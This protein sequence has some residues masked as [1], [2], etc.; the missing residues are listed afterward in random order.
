MDAQTFDRFTMNAV[1]NATR[2]TALGLLLGGM[3]GLAGLDPGDAKGKKGG[4]GKGKKKKKNRKDQAATD[5]EA[6]DKACGQGG[7]AYGAACCFNYNC[8][9]CSSSNCV[10]TPPGTP[11][12]CG[13][14]PGET[15]FNGSCGLKPE[16]LPAGSVR[17][18]DDIRC[19]SGIE[20]EVDGDVFAI[21]DPGYL[22]CLD[23]ADCVGGSCRGYVCAAPTLDC[24]AS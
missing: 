6:L 5:C 24:L 13:C 2:R 10:G 7:C 21:C 19:C 14:L 4:K 16:C 11:G 17:S 8:D 12:T 20:H 9:S 3:L 22:S 1:T 15:F 18:F 23:N